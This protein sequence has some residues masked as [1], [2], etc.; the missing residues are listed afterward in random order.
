MNASDP[1]DH[2]P[3]VS[4]LLINEHARFRQD[5]AGVLGEHD[6]LLRR[7]AFEALV[8]DLVQ[9]ETAEEETVYPVIAKL[10]GGSDLRAEAVR[11]ERELDGCLA[12]TMRRLFWRPQGRKS[13]RLIEEFSSMLDRHFAFE[14]RSLISVVTAFE[15]E[16]KRQMMGTW[17]QHAKTVAPTRPHPHGPRHLPGLLTV[18][19]ALA[20]VDRMR[21]AGRNLARPRR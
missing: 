14:E 12:H 19:I 10:E 20:F 2:G 5:M 13:R 3:D 16:R 17:T 18:G 9:H 1:V 15:D 7:H 4:S 8:R 11:Q 6:A 21:D